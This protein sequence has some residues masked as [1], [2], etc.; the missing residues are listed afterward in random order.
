MHRV[1]LWNN[2]PRGDFGRSTESDFE[3]C[4]TSKLLGA[5]GTRRAAVGGPGRQTPPQPT[6]RPPGRSPARRRV[7]DGPEE[8]RAYGPELKPSHTIIPSCSP[9]SPSC[10]PARRQQEG[11]GREPDPHGWLDASRGN[12]QIPYG[13]R[14]GTFRARAAIAGPPGTATAGVARFSVSASPRPPPSGNV[15][16]PSPLCRP[17]RRETAA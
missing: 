13:P 4:R 11:A 9:P 2:R 16:R 1:L 6:Q 12:R 15:V 10:L 8:Y 7:S 17:E 14:R 3:P 5:A